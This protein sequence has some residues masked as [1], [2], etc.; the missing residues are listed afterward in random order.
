MA[1]RWSG[2]PAALREELQAAGGVMPWRRLR[3]ALVARY[4]AAEAGSAADGD[5]AWVGW[6]ALASIP[7]SFLS[8]EDALVRLPTA[9]GPEP[10]AK[11]RRATDGAATPK[12]PSATHEES[13]PT[14]SAREHKAH[15]GGLPFAATEGEISKFFAGCGEVSQCDLLYTHEGKSRGIAF[16]T[17]A[18]RASLDAALRLS[19]SEFGGRPIKVSEA[20]GAG[21]RD[22][23]GKGKGKSKDKGRD[24]SGNDKSN[25]KGKAKSRD[26][27]DVSVSGGKGPGIENREFEVFVG[28][29]PYSVPAE[30]IEKDFRDCG[31]T[32]RFHIPLNEDGAHK[33]IAFINYLAREGMEKALGFND[34]EYGGVWIR[35]QKADAPRSQGGGKPKGPPE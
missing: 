31:E 24:K 21:K 27:F 4:R 35:V 2:W 15:V 9:E 19:D 13:G 11:R 30:T 14:V 18:S 12:A 28:G 5:H 22:G 1:A 29:L 8:R 32:G 33:G 10:A 20:V 34:Q 25:G 7:A 6:C 16:L 26:R 17:F 3:D 23:A